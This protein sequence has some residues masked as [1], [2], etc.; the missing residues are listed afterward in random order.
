MAIIGSQTDLHA[1]RLPGIRPSTAV[2]FGLV[3]LRVRRSI[4]DKTVSDIVTG[5]EPGSLTMTESWWF[6]VERGEVIPTPQSVDIIQRLLDR[7]G[8]T[9]Q[10]SMRTLLAHLELEPYGALAT[11]LRSDFKLQVTVDELEQDRLDFG[12]SLAPIAD[13]IS[14]RDRFLVLG[15]LAVCIGLTKVLFDLNRW[16][17]TGSY[18]SNSL[19]SVVLVGALVGLAAFFVGSLDNF[20]GSIAQSVRQGQ[21]LENHERFHALRSSYGLRPGIDRWFEASDLPHLL[22]RVRPSY[23][24]ACIWADFGERFRGLLVL[25]FLAQSTALFSALAWAGQPVRLPLLI[26]AMLVI[27]LI[28]EVVRKSVF[29]WSMKGREHLQ[30]G[31]GYLETD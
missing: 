29:R 11:D 10:T 25:I 6:A 3:V 7:S 1:D 21:T 15:P 26:A 5:E 16:V 22:A 14:G 4:Q 8:S 18:E 30:R 31:L 24:S 23:R 2:L 12:T 27:A 19:D 13:E 17:W 28:Q 20:L 9:A